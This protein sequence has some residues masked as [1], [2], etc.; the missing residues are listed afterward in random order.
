MA[1]IKKKG[2]TNHHHNPIAKKNPNNLIKKWAKNLNRHF[3]KEDIQMANRYL[4]RRSTSLIIQEIKIK[5]SM[6]YQLTCIR[7]VI[8]KK[9]SDNKCWW[10]CGRKGTL[11]HC[12]WE[13]KLVQPLQK[14][15]WR[16]L[17]KLKIKL[18]YDPAIPLLGVYPKKTIIQKD[19][20]TPVFI[21]ALFTIG[22][23]SN[24]NVH[25]QMNG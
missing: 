16:F 13:H 8:S 25:P 5:T 1:V 24:L 23:G 4:K 12:W 21:A 11:M 17:K 20:C 7:I 14:I 19:T 2:K 3:P 10:G 6:R 18:P 22:H 15:I 9:T